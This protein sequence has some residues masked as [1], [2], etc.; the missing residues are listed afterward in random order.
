MPLGI[1][2]SRRNKVPRILSDAE[3]ANLEEFIDGINYSARYSDSEYEYRHVQIPKA[4]LNAIPED[5]RDPRTGTL[6]LLWEDE[7]RSIGI[8]QSLGWEHYE[9]HEPEPHI[10][11][12]K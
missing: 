3:R 9:V 4:M 1:D 2:T 10:L 8:T 7:W 6:K 11:L 5:Y 12:F